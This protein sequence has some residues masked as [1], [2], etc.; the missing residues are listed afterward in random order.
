MDNIDKLLD[1]FDEF[2]TI[3]KLVNRESISNV[4]INELKN[5]KQLFEIYKLTDGVNST[6]DVVKKLT[7]KCT[8]AT[9]ANIW[10]RWAIKG[11]VKESETRGRYKAIFDLEEY[12]IEICEE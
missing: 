11:I 1:S 3:Y 7:K 5:D 12:G 4:I 6:R 9:I 8:H 10:K 2:L